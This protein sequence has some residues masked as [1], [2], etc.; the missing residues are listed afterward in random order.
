MQHR[1]SRERQVAD[2]VL[3]ASALA[4]SS[5]RA[6]YSLSHLRRLSSVSVTPYIRDSRYNKSDIKH[7]IKHDISNKQRA[8]SVPRQVQ[9]PH[10]PSS[11]HHTLQSTRYLATAP[12]ATKLPNPKPRE[13]NKRAKRERAREQEQQRGDQR[14]GELL[15]VS[16]GYN[17]R[18]LVTVSSLLFSAASRLLASL[19]R[20]LS[21]RSTLASVFSVE[22]LSLL[23]LAHVTRR[24]VDSRPVTPTPCSIK[25]SC[26][27]RR[28]I[29]TI[30]VP[31]PRGAT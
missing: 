22:L 14:N 17:H 15:L 13:P 8:R 2:D 24:E 10:Q 19:A 20:P 9:S 23:S 4:C 30:A 31:R 1:E 28:C 12:A 18:L 11:Q 6:K 5:L 27:C 29:R 26:R 3:S 25:Q 16:P 21:L 7:D